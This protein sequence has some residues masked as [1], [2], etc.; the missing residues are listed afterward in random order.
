M[1][2]TDDEYELYEQLRNL[3]NAMPEADRAWAEWVMSEKELRH[4]DR[5]LGLTLRSDEALWFGP[6]TNLTIFGKPIR[7][8]ESAEGINLGPRPLVA[9][10]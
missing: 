4:I 10:L 6:G 3:W 9:A 7:L 5:V 1:F 2:S 8:D